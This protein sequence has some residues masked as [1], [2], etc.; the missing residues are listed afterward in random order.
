MS[1]VSR[2]LDYTQH[3]EAPEVFH[4]WSAI[5]T[6]AATLNRKCFLVRASSKSHLTYISYPGQLMIVLVAGAGRMRKS[7]TVGFAEKLLQEADSAYVYDGKISPERLLAKLGDLPQGAIMTV[8]ADELSYFLSKA[9]YAESM[10]QNILE[11]S[12]AKSIGSYETQKKTKI[13]KNVCFTGLFATT[14]KSL[15]ESIPETAHEDGFL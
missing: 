14:P 9:Q 1:F 11:L 12:S 4:K 7:T 5:A 13:L 6:I 10:V 15:G 8:I 3:H 2:Y